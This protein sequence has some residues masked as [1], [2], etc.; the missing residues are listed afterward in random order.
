M[1]PAKVR[2]AWFTAPT[3]NFSVREGP[4]PGLGA[5]QC[6]LQSCLMQIEALRGLS[7]RP[8]GG[9]V[10]GSDWRQDQESPSCVHTYNDCVAQTIAWVR[11]HEINALEGATSLCLLFSGAQ[12]ICQP[13]AEPTGRYLIVYQSKSAAPAALQLRR[14]RGGWWCDWHLGGAALGSTWQSQRSQ[15]P[16]LLL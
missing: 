13:S 9:Q 7:A 10:R 4:V 12:N 1:K 2:T 14:G 8:V 11:I 3:W 15:V 6:K 16:R 5:L